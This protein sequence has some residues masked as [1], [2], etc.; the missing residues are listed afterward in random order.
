MYRQI[1]NNGHWSGQAGA[2]YSGAIVAQSGHLDALVALERIGTR[3]SFARNAEI[4]AEGG[5]SDYWYKVV[6][7]SVRICKLLADGRRHIAEFCFSGDCFGLE[8][9]SER[10]YSAE[11]VD[12]VIIMRY[13]RSATEQMVDQHPS[14]ARLLRDTVLRE[15]SNAH[16]RMLMLGRMTAPERV[17]AFLLQMYE[18]RA[19]TKVL[20]LPMSRI[21]IADYL[22]LTIETV[23]RILSAFK[24]EEVIAIPNPHRIEL[25]DRCALEAINEA[26]GGAAI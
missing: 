21:D 14:L 10:I 20:D 24:R 7:G 18:R 9:G 26:G 8:N 23:C 11:A 17:A 1:S 15:L 5:D 6:S 22:G 19:R 4:Y 3:L 16:G 13:R 2:A 12:E 25:L